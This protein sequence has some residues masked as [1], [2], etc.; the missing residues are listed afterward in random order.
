MKKISKIKIKNN[1][2]KKIVKSKT[3]IKIKTKT[4]AKTKTKTKTTK[5]NITLKAIKKTKSNKK[6]LKI[7]KLKSKNNQEKRVGLVTHYFNKIKV[8]AVKLQGPLSIGDTIRIKGGQ[9]TNFKQ[10]VSSLELNNEKIK[11]GK[12]GQTVGIKTKEKVR[13]G[14][15]VYKIIQ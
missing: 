7:I 6:N 5:S 11:Q 8:M 2:Q 4:K 12:K 15:I 14:Y 1:S 10:K 3:K 13:E 9:G